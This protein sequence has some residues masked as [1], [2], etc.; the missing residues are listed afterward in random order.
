MAK[1][2]RRLMA[3]C[4]TPDLHPLSWFCG[5]LIPS[6]RHTSTPPAHFLPQQYYRTNLIV[7]AGSRTDPKPRQL[8]YCSL[9]I[10]CL[11]LCIFLTRYIKKNCVFNCY[12]KGILHYHFIS[13]SSLRHITLLLLINKTQKQFMLNKLSA[14]ILQCTTENVFNF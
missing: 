8:I 6:W 2:Q 13:F 4:K 10:N 9:N 12:F 3:T 14:D 7:T 11:V 1:R 5:Q